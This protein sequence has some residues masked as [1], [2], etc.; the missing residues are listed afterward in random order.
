MSSRTERTLD[1]LP[2]YGKPLSAW[3][4][5]ADR[6]SDPRRWIRILD[7]TRHG[8]ERDDGCDLVVLAP[9]GKHLRFSIR[10]QRRLSSSASLRATIVGA[11][12]GLVRPRSLSKPELEDIWTGLVTLATVTACQDDG[13]RRASGSMKSSAT[14]NASRTTP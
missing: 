8:R 12:D 10:E 14:P 4:R 3:R 7:F 9:G 1:Y 2:D 13:S 6:R 5:L 11:T